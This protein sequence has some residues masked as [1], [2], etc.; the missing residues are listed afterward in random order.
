MMMA[1]SG[2]VCRGGAGR[3]IV[4]DVGDVRLP[5]IPPRLAH[6]RRL[7]AHHHHHPR[8]AA[9]KVR[10]VD[11]RGDVPHVGA[12]EEV[13]NVRVGGPNDADHLLL[14]RV[15]PAAASLLAVNRVIATTNLEGADDPTKM[16]RRQINHPPMARTR[17]RSFHPLKIFHSRNPTNPPRI[18][19][20]LPLPTTSKQTMPCPSTKTTYAKPKTSK[21]PSKAKPT[22]TAPTRIPTPPTPVPNPSPKAIPS[23]PPIKPPPPAN[24]TDPPSSPERARRSHSTYNRTCVS[25]VVERLAFPPAI[26][27]RLRRVA[28]LCRGRVMLG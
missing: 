7:R 15:R 19:R 13:R 9:A 14:L 21:K 23:K 25:R 1:K 16:E 24:P 4:V 2:V 22:T 10:T 12:L 20:M 18:P 27:T 17:R 8:A 6:R 11:E 26:L 28:S 3:R 5:V